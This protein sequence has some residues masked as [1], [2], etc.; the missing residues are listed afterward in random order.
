VFVVDASD[1]GRLDAAAAELLAMAAD[2]QL[3][4]VPFV[5]I[6]N[7]ADRSGALRREELVARLAIDTALGTRG[8]QWELH[9]I[10]GPL[11][12]P[13]L[14]PALDFLLANMHRL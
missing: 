2:D 14:Q 9:L 5:V 4:G 6:A 8:H 3:S 10:S 13:A 1:A 11:T 7:K 12:P